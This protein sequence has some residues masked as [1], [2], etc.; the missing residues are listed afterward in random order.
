[1]EGNLISLLCESSGIPPPNLVW[2]KKGQFPSFDIYEIKYKW[3]IEEFIFIWQT[4]QMINKLSRGLHTKLPDRII[5]YYMC[6]MW[7]FHTKQLKI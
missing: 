3:N 1:M 7:Y 2:K 6:N 5:K 4:C